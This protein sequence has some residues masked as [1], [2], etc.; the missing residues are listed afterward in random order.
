MM[1]YTEVP[2]TSRIGQEEGSLMAGSSERRSQR[3]KMEQLACDKLAR[4]LDL[5]VSKYRHA[6]RHMRG[7][8]RRG[9]IT[10]TSKR[11]TRMDKTATERFVLL[12]A[13]GLLTTLRQS[14]GGLLPQDTS[15]EELQTFG[16]RFLFNFGQRLGTSDSC[17]LEANAIQAS[18][19]PA[20]S[21]ER[22]WA[23]MVLL[24]RLFG[25][26]AMLS[27]GGWGSADFNFT[28]EFLRFLTGASP[29][30]FKSSSCDQTCQKEKKE[31]QP[32]SQSSSPPA[33]SLFHVRISVAQ[34]VEAVEFLK[35]EEREGINSSTTTKGNNRLPMSGEPGAE[36]RHAAEPVCV[37][38]SGYINGF[39]KHMVVSCSVAHGAPLHL[40]ADDLAT[41]EIACR[42]RGAECCQF[43][44]TTRASILSH[45]L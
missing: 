25:L 31:L 22:V 26:P 39:I 32:T 2:Y 29:S 28:P 17:L 9:I 1:I 35:H 18:T 21:E 6:F 43:V 38:L 20:G 36:Q 19:T 5:C 30:D 7:D 11:R 40:V 23:C 34:S 3:P 10:L 42:A 45:M 27:S 8:L 13:E 37:M 12:R 4:M 15:P 14:L 33:S 41:T 24:E 44:T 16:N